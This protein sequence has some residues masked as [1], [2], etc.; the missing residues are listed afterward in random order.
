MF[1][2]PKKGDKIFSSYLTAPHTSSGHL[3]RPRTYGWQTRICCLGRAFRSPSPYLPI[4][5][6]LPDLPVFHPPINQDDD[7]LSTSVAPPTLT[8]QGSPLQLYFGQVAA[9]DAPFLCGCLFDRGNRRS[10]RVAILLTVHCAIETIC[11]IVRWVGLVPERGYRV[12]RTVGCLYR[13]LHIC[14]KC[15][16]AIAYDLLR[17]HECRGVAFETPGT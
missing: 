3:Q 13:N 11:V 2:R 16:S 14:A 4:G 17:Q 9:N 1:A 7:D 10:L 15:F 12:V 8:K 5:L 6:Y